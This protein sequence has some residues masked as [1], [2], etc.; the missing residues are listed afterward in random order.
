MSVM[1]L[2]LSQKSVSCRIARTCRNL[3]KN[4][5][6]RHRADLVTKGLMA[7]TEYAAGSIMGVAAAQNKI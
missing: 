4:R 6:R 7:G 1:P 5:G 2:K 3:L